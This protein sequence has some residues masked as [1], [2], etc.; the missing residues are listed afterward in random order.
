VLIGPLDSDSYKKA[1][2]G[3]DAIGLSTFA[4]KYQQ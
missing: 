1:K 2:D 3:V 4:R